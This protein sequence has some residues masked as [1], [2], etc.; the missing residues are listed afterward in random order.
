M[1]LNDLVF[2]LQTVNNLNPVARVAV[3]ESAASFICA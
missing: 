2:N 3:G 1:T